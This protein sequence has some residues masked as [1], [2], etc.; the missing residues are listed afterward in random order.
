[1][2][3]GVLVLHLL[4]FILIG[5]LPVVFFARGGF[6]WRW[7]LTGAPFFVC[8]LVLAGVLAG[9]VEPAHASGRWRLL[10]DSVSVVL[11]AGSIAL[12]AFTL[13]THRIPIALWHQEHDAPRQI[14]SW[15]AYAR[16]RHPFYAAFLLALLG[17]LVV[18]PH[19]FTLLTLVY[20]LVV[21][22]LTAAREERR[23]LGSEFGHEY[24]DYMRRT[25][26]FVPRWR[27]AA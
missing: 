26:R 23:L 9:V 24:R 20:G 15:G 7:W 4:A 8:A 10:L 27:A 14:V 6:T 3:A 1:M 11:A 19:G 21:L 2:S 13:G 25:G 12:V 5:L 17:A 18:A 22:N 16:I